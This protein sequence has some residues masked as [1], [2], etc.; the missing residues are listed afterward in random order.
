LFTDGCA[1]RTQL[2]HHAGEAQHE[3]LDDLTILEFES[4]VLTSQLL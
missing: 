2:G 3:V 1:Q 4:F